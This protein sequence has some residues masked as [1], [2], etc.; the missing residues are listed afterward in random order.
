MNWLVLVF[1]VIGLLGLVGGVPK[2]LHGDTH[3]V[4]LISVVAC[5]FLVLSSL[6][7]L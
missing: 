2:I 4:L 1:L 5:V 3:P 7:K 6:T